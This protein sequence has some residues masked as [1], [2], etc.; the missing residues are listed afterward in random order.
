M[1]SDSFRRRLI[2]KAPG[3]KCKQC[4]VERAQAGRKDGLGRN[5]GDTLDKT[6]RIAKEAAE[7]A[8]RAK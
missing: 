7:A 1:G 8:A 2:P 4:G 3:P 6:Q 5:C